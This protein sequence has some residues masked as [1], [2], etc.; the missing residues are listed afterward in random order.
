MHA[1]HRTILHFW[2]NQDVHRCLQVGSHLSR[3]WQF[4]SLSDGV[5]G[6]RPS[7]L[8]W[9]QP[10]SWPFLLFLWS[11]PHVSL[12]CQS[13]LCLTSMAKTDPHHPFPLWVLMVLG[14]VG[15]LTCWKQ[16]KGQSGQSLKSTYIPL[17]LRAH[18][19]KGKRPVILN[20][21]DFE[22]FK[23]SMLYNV[24]HVLYMKVLQKRPCSL[25]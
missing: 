8:W 5:V 15:A 14:H 20:G 13:I 21:M 24:V 4:M 11:I 12:A 16:D 10:M 25:D 2:N 9:C 1:G 23:K 7:C 6:A 17:H 3:I 18:I 19:S 22:C